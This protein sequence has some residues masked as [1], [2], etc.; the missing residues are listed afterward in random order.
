[1]GE[2]PRG[3]VVK[4]RWAQIRLQELRA[5]LEA[6]GREDPYRIV[7]QEDT[8]GGV[9]RYSLNHVVPTPNAIEA[10]I[11]ESLYHMRSLLD[12]LVVGLGGHSFPVFDRD[13]ANDA[14]ALKRF[15]ESLGEVGTLTRAVVVSHQP[16]QRGDGFIAHPIYLLNRIHIGYKHHSLDHIVAHVNYPW[17]PGVPEG[18][19]VSLPEGTE[20][21]VVPIEFDPRK[22][23]EPYTSVEIKFAEA[24]RGL[25]FSLG[26]LLDMH[27]YIRTEVLPSF[28]PLFE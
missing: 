7:R 16:Y 14:K 26:S 18:R 1:M 8:E 20:F 24:G 22:N 11:D 5:E 15:D 21:A 10:L 9:V 25:G 3:P 4:L 19:S 28:E 17:F 6:Y 23:F 2:I 12:L 13:P 27:D